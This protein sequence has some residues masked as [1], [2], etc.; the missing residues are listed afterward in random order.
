MT[1]FY[2]L[3]FL[4]LL[5]IVAPDIR[6]SHMGAM[7][8]FVG[9]AVDGV[10]ALTGAS[11]VYLALFIVIMVVYATGLT[12]NREH[13]T[14]TVNANTI[15]ANT[16]FADVIKGNMT[17]PLKLNPTFETAEYNH[18]DIPID[19]KLRLDQLLT[20][21]LLIQTH[22]RLTPLSWDFVRVFDDGEK[23]YWYIEGF[24][25]NSENF[26]SEKFIWV[27]WM[28][29]PDQYRLVE[30]RP[31]SMKDSTTRQNTTSGDLQNPLQ[32]NLD[33]G[34]E[35]EGKTQLETT[36]LCPKMIAK[37]NSRDGKQPYA[38]T[39]NKWILPDTIYDKNAYVTFTPDIL[40]PINYNTGKFADLFSR[41]R[42]DPSFPHGT[43][44]A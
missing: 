36:V 34:L 24:L 38:R 11:K 27:F 17:Q 39:Y 9:P 18:N 33:A 16:R 8:Q 44:T 25:Q 41:T 1:L 10:E 43:S 21:D 2:F 29:K 30:I 35:A 40:N 28:L 20:N 4:V 32:V 15:E 42:H 22:H 3:I 14:N 23:S 5:Y 6:Q 13:M 19:I 37:I 26:T 12:W 7:A 31:Y